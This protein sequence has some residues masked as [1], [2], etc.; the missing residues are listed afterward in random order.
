MT[1]SSEDIDQLAVA[2]VLAQADI[3][4]ADK[5]GKGNYGKY[6]TLRS[7]WDA[8]K[9]ALQ[10]Q[11]LCVL[12]FSQPSEPGTLALTTMLLHK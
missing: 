2:I 4:R 3:E 1:G 5:D 6:T 11:G 8:C 9:P 7:V 12:Q 10:A